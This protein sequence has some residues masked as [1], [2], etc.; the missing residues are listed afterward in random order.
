M[1]LLLFYLLIINQSVEMEKGKRKV[2]VKMTSTALWFEEME[3]LGFVWWISFSLYLNGIFLSCD[4]LVEKFGSKKGKLAKQNLINKYKELC[5][6]FNVY[7]RIV[8]WVTW[9]NICHISNLF[10]VLNEIGANWLDITD[11]PLMVI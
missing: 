4:W 1:Q 6:V 2:N 9:V 8:T 5:K 7:F 3:L 10:S 11:I